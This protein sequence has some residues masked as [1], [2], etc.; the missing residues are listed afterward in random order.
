MIFPYWV[1]LKA[2]LKSL[3][4]LDTRILSMLSGVINICW[5]LFVVAPYLLFDV[6]PTGIFIRLAFQLDDTVVFCLFTCI[7]VLGLSE[8]LCAVINHYWCRI[9]V[10]LISVVWWSFL[11]AVAAIDPPNVSALWQ[12]APMAFFRMWTFVT[13]NNLHPERTG[14]RGFQ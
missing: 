6:V 2:R 14:T 11:A 5:A 3:E 4:F 13:I 10:S 8:L 1:V 12:F 7:L 9:C